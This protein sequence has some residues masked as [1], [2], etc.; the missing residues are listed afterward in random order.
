M[1]AAAKQW[2]DKCGK[3]PWQ[4][5]SIVFRVVWPILYTLYAALLWLT[6]SKPEA[7]GYLLAGLALNLCWVPL[8]I[9][10]VQAAFLLILAMVL[11]GIQTIQVLY[12]GPKLYVYLFAPYLVWITFA[13]TLNAYLAWTC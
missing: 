4:P 1:A 6:W 5:P 9:F 8:Y 13:S 11:V 3:V 10:N 12:K 2:F 7:R